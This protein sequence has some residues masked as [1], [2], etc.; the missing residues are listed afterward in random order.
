MSIWF[1]VCFSSFK[2]LSY[3]RKLR[4]YEE[5]KKYVSCVIPILEDDHC[6]YTVGFLFILPGMFSWVSFCSFFDLA[7]FNIT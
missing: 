7:I 5:Y 2:V 1:F 3:S 4:E 6:E